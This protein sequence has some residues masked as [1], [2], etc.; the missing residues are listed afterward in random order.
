[1]YVGVDGVGNKHWRAFTGIL[2]A[3]WADLADQPDLKF[4]DRNILFREN[5]PN[6]PNPRS[7]KS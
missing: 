6:P 4:P 1:V 7:K 3:D 2:N 5:P